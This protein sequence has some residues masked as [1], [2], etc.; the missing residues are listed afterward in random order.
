MLLFTPT[1]FQQARK[2]VV[3]VFHQPIDV[4]EP[5]NKA[6]N[7]NTAAQPESSQTAKNELYL[8][9]CER[10]RHQYQHLHGQFRSLGL[11]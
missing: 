4:A 9:V 2:P 10:P 5:E 7:R 11:N 3:V 6:P 8:T 1:A